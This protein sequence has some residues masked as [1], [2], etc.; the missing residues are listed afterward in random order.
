L[1]EHNNSFTVGKLL[2]KTSCTEEKEEEQEEKDEEDEDKKRAKR[3][4]VYSPRSA[5]GGRP[6][7]RFISVRER[8]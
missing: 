8:G 5:W 1:H 6:H 2:E 4:R 7:R 3:Q